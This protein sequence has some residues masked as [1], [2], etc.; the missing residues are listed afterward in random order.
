LA[1]TAIDGLRV[2]LHFAFVSTITISVP[3]PLDATLTERMNAVGASSKEQYL[4]SLVEADCAAN[5]LEQKLAE[6]WDGPFAPLASDWKDQ[7]R[8]AAAQRG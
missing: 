8:Q 2:P 6:R 1:R 7:V 5:E 4:L 3:D